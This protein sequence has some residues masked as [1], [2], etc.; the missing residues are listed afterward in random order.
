[1]TLYTVRLNREVQLT[2]EGIEADSPEAAAEMACDQHP[3]AAHDTD[4]CDGDAF[5]AEVDDDD[6][7]E[8]V[9]IEFEPERLRQAA[10]KLLAAASKALKRMAEVYRDTFDSRMDNDPLVIELRAA[11]AEVTASQPRVRP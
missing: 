2:F 1:M 4:S 3:A 5:S 8:S 7:G 10:P 9:T 11:I 6:S